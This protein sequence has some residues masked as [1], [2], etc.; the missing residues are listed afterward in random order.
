MDQ[1]SRRRILATTAAG[2]L[3]TAAAAQ[4]QGTGPNSDPGPANPALAAMN[5]SAFSPPKTDHGDMPTFKYPF[6]V[7][8]NR[9]TAGGWARQVTV[10]DFPIAKSIAGVNMRLAA[11]AV[12]ELHW[13]LPSEWA[14]MSYG[15]ARI[16]AIDPQGRHFAADV[17]QGDLWFFPSGYPHSIQGLGPDGCE[18]LLAFDDGAF[19]EDSTLL[20]TDWV[21]HTPRDV[22]GASLGVD[23]SVFDKAPKEELYIFPAPLPGSLQDDLA[24]SPNPVV[25]EPFNFAMTD[26]KPNHSVKGGTVRIVDSSNFKASKTIAAA[27]VELNP[28]G[29]RVLHWHP[30]ADEWQY[31]LSGTG[32]MTVFPGGAKAHTEDFAAGDVG[33]IERSSGHYIQNTGADVL[34]FL[35][36]FASDHYAEV[37]LAEWMANTPHELVAAHL[38]ID[39][40]V[41]ASLPKQSF[42]V[43]PV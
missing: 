33:Y 2:G 8:Y 29:T 5:P 17:K 21:A 42:P 43:V 23:P 19:S 3:F 1:I 39:P 26:M 16:T 24:Q 7:E 35:E 9:H 36:I 25:P 20:I 38:N 13:H 22:L 6:N 4:A 12:R 34:R 40:Q 41:L 10:K 32:R 18:F 27:L 31:Y 37:T 14:Y 30:N 11:G 28:G 15:T